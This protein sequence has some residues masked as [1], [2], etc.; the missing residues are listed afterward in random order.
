MERTINVVKT[1]QESL[2]PDTVE[3]TL[4]AAADAKRYSSA[5]SAAEHA[6]DDV[7]TALKSAGFAEVKMCG[8]TAEKIQ[9]GKTDCYRASKTFKLTFAY[10]AQK[11]A[12]ALDA[13][14]ECPCT[15]RIGFLLK[16]NEHTSRLMQ[17]AVIEAKASA[18]TLANAAGIKLGELVKIEYCQAPQGG[19]V[20]AMRAAVADTVEPQSVSLSETVN[21]TWAIE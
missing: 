9:N 15:H 17:N 14:S 20:F 18:Q 11:F 7:V 1:V 16:S 21:C 12:A 13:I 19:R 5:V 2:P 4:C 10:S 6:A 3:I 8:V